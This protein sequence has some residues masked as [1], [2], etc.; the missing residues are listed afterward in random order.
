MKTKMTMK[1]SSPNA[2]SNSHDASAE[3]RI[4]KI[5]C[6]ITCSYRRVLSRRGAPTYDPEV[7]LVE[8]IGIR[9]CTT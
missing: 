8:N 9:Y 2:D 3:V 1:V 4:T 6:N 5:W 7:V